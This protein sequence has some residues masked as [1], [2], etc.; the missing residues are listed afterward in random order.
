MQEKDEIEHIS[1]Y[2]DRT[3]YW[4]QVIQLILIWSK[5]EQKKKQE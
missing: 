2:D 4:E 3:I 1:P 5:L